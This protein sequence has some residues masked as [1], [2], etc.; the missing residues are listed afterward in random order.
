[1]DEAVSEEGLLM[2]SGYSKVEETR[3]CDLQLPREAHLMNKFLSLLQNEERDRHTRLAMSSL[4]SSDIHPHIECDKPGPP[5]L[6]TYA[7]RTGA[8]NLL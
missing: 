6:L 3:L 5:M 7:I 8:T 1:M 4:V 2:V